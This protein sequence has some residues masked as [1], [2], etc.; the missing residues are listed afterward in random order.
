MSALEPQGTGFSEAI[1]TLEAEVKTLKAE[2]A[3]LDSDN[4]GAYN[5]IRAKD[6]QLD[7]MA[8]EVEEAR[9]ILIQNGV[10]PR[11]C[12]SMRYAEAT[13]LQT[14]S[15]LCIM[16]RCFSKG[17]VLGALLGIAQPLLQTLQELQNY[18]LQMRSQLQEADQ[19]K[20]T[21][22]MVQRQNKADIAKLTEGLEAA[23]DKRE[24][25]DRELALAQTQLKVLSCHLRLKM[26]CGSSYLLARPG[27][28]QA[29]TACKWQT[30]T[31]SGRA[32]H[33]CSQTVSWTSALGPMQ[34]SQ[35]SAKDVASELELRESELTRV[36]AVASRASV[37]EANSIKDE[38]MVPFALHK[39]EVSATSASCRDPSGTDHRA[40]FHEQ[41]GVI[42]LHSS[43]TRSLKSATIS[44]GHAGMEH[45]GEAAPVA[46]KIAVL[47]TCQCW[48]AATGD[49]PEGRGGPAEGEAATGRQVCSCHPAAD[50]ASVCPGR[51]PPRQ[52]KRSQE[53]VLT[54]MQ[55]ACSHWRA[56]KLSTMVC[57][58]YHLPLSV[59]RRVPGAPYQS[60]FK[61]QLQP[62]IQQNTGIEQLQT[63]GQD[64]SATAQAP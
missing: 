1:A 9:R 36:A 20:A 58:S 55:H 31:P 24:S 28:Y 46:I 11:F 40:T 57:Q 49:A 48:C 52:R 6:K 19:E 18:I 30:V 32:M 10:S 29:P 12:C 13:S 27:V 43:C 33:S 21:L 8:L 44:D 34:A 50:A 23:K 5:Q 38:G 25:L 47:L 42:R 64:Q 45:Q 37:R 22:L 61:R 53:G 51:R 56:L 7:T 26:A 3:H 17:P 14:N 4:K 59:H 63:G 39:E 2:N 54:A 15:L 41:H 60:A 16:A 62:V 35:R